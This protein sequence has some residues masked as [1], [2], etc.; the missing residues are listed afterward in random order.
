[1]VESQGG[2]GMG[3]GVVHALQIK[4]VISTES[5]VAVEQ[6][7]EM[8]AKSDAP[9]GQQKQGGLNGGNKAA[10]PLVPHT[11]EFT[12]SPVELRVGAEKGVQG[13]VLYSRRQCQD[14]HQSLR[15]GEGASVYQFYVWAI[16]FSQFRR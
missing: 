11:A 7:G 14:H 9:A 4:D 16:V 15:R 3:A 8:E 13:L 1:M 12:V 5:V 10:A 6:A 2:A